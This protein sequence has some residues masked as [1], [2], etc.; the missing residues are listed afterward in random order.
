MQCY[1]MKHNLQNMV[2]QYILF[3]IYF[4]NRY[5][6]ANLHFLEMAS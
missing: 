3:K 2:I 6:E 4:A 5:I 1:E